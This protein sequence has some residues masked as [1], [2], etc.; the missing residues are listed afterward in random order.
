M[1]LNSARAC[2][3]AARADTAAPNAACSRPALPLQAPLLPEIQLSAFALLVRVKQP[4]GGLLSVCNLHPA[5]SVQHA[6]L[7]GV[8]IEGVGFQA[9]MHPEESKAC[10]CVDSSCYEATRHPHLSEARYSAWQ[11]CSSTLSVVPFPRACFPMHYAVSH[12]AS[13]LV[14]CVHTACAA[15]AAVQVPDIPELE[16]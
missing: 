6:L 4:A 11:G 16:S 5:E 3:A 1:G 10:P 14:V 13:V 9:C 7:A 12:R 15:C 8:T 2:A